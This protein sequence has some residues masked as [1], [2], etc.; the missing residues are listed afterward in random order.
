MC[1]RILFLVAL[2]P[3]PPPSLA[4][5]MIAIIIS[6][7][8]AVGHQPLAVVADISSLLPDTPHINLLPAFTARG[9][10]VRERN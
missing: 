8:D 5:L 3:R 2:V 9:E 6:F 10:F 4:L 1:G 7:L